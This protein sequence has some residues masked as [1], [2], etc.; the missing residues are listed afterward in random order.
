MAHVKYSWKNFRD[1]LQNRE[2]HESLAQRTF[3]RLWYV[4]PLQQLEQIH[5]RQLKKCL[6]ITTS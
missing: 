5:T 6:P 2:N 3:P 1:P 4:T